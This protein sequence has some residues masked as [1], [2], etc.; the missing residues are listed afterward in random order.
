MCS[1][2]FMSL[3]FLLCFRKAFAVCYDCFFR[4]ND[5][6]TGVLCKPETPALAPHFHRR[7]ICLSLQVLL[8][9]LHPFK[10]SRETDRERE[11]ERERERERET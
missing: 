6:V 9:Q 4:F 3:Q 8:C 2:A 5:K 10:G 1:L 11:S 7:N